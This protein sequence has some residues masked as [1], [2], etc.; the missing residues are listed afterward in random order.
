MTYLQYKKINLGEGKSVDLEHDVARGNEERAIAIRAF[1]RN[2]IF[3]R[4]KHFF[5]R[6]LYRSPT[7][8]T[9]RPRQISGVSKRTSRRQS[10]L[11]A[12]Y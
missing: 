4:I 5:A 2:P 11:T 10:A 6:S 1:V 8:A 9:K 7:N 3:R 12:S